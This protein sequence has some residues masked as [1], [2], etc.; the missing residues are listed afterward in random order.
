MGLGL[1][2]SIIINVHDA[3]N[4]I[5]TGH[6]PESAPRANDC[7]LGARRRCHDH[8]RRRRCR[9]ACANSRLGFGDYT[10][11]LW[12]KGY[13]SLRGLGLRAYRVD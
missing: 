13:I 11:G 12:G 1:Q 7:H 9:G 8:W 10:M 5:C 6:I 4:G 3:T 2:W